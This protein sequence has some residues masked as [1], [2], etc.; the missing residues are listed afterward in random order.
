MKKKLF[1]ILIAVAMVLTCIPL[2]FQTAS[3]ATATYAGTFPTL[4]NGIEAK[5]IE[6]TWASGT[7]KS[8]YTYPG[9]D[10]TAA[11][12]TALNN[13]YPSRSGWDAATKVGASC[14]V[15]VGTVVRNCY[16]TSYPRGLEQQISYLPKCG[17][18]TMV[19]DI[20]TYKS[21]VLKPGDIFVYSKKAGGAHTAVY[22][23]INGKGY[24][25]EAHY[26]KYYP[27]ICRALPSF[28][29]SIY[30]RFEVWRANGTCNGALAKGQY[31]TNVKNL[32]SFLN[33]AGFDCGTPDGAF[34]T[35][36]ENAVKEYQAAVG[37]TADGKFGSQSLEKAKTYVQ[38]QKPISVLPNTTS[39]GTTAQKTTTTKTTASVSTVVKKAYTGKLPTKTIKKKKGSK[40]NIKR[41]Q[42]FLKWYGYPITTGGTFGT[43]TIKYTKAF[44]KSVG[45]KA[46]GIV[47]AKTRAKAKTVKK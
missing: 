41:W 16:D 25:A 35:N 8:K 28:D 27:A 10:S 42:K 11:F 3:A 21:S 9:G 4:C 37:L 38:G 24:M 45:I 30:K 36:T 15:F 20:N 32:Q 33:W 6:Y 7:A 43:K 5:A 1:A 44:Q 26:Q 17:K 39:S 29:M 2:N 47:G 23:T 19:A 18:F 13:A 14:D 31:S 40:T 12:K 22:I 46:D 34:G